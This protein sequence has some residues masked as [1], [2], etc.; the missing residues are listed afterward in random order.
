MTDKRR[1]Q[2][3]IQLINKQIELE[4]QM[5]RQMNNY[6]KSDEQ[7]YNRIKQNHIDRI[8]VL[9]YIKVRL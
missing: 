7:D 8:S 3:A 6:I 5:L 9:S 2:E 4:E 1:R